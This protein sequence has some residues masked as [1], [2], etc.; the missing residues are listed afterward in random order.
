M[1]AGNL[2][3]P[4][5]NKGSVEKN[6]SSRKEIRKRGVAVM[7]DQA[8]LFLYLNFL[9]SYYQMHIQNDFLYSYLNNEKYCKAELLRNTLSKL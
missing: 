7:R 6:T 9:F 8:V 1:E 2:P 4:E 3:A 5:G